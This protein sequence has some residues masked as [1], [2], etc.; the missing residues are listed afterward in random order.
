VLVIIDRVVEAMAWM[1]RRAPRRRPS[2]GSAMVE[3]GRVVG[4]AFMTVVG[5]VGERRPSAAWRT[6]CCAG[7]ARTAGRATA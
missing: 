4:V 6:N 1:G 2:I 7:C 3:C 5:A